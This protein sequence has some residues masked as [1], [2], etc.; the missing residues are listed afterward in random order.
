MNFN[1]LWV[2]MVT[3]VANFIILFKL[4]KYTSQKTLKKSSYIWLDFKQSKRELQNIYIGI[5]Q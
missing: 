4:L 3:T 5:K 2:I 1:F